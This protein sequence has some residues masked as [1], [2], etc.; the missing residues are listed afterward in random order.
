MA[1]KMVKITLLVFVLTLCLVYAMA[2]DSARRANWPSVRGPNAN[3]V[4]EGYAVPTAW[5]IESSKNCHSFFSVSH[6]NI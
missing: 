1:F 2:E 4:A 3:G 5:D 6:I